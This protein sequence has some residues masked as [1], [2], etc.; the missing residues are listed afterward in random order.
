MHSYDAP[1]STRSG[2]V[3]VAARTDDHCG[4]SSYIQPDQRTH[5]LTASRI[6]AG[7]RLSGSNIVRQLVNL[8]H[9]NISDGSLRRVRLVQMSN[10]LAQPLPSNASLDVYCPSGKYSPITAFSS[11]GV[12]VSCAALL[13]SLA[14]SMFRMIKRESS[15]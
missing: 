2:D 9:E 8:V 1:G 10:Y 12:L 3:A 4:E 15:R 11:P 6:A 5:A 13:N 7:E 14:G